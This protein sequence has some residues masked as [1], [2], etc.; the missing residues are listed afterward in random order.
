[1][2]SCA[3]AGSQ[4]YLCRR[5]NLFTG[6]PWHF[7]FSKWADLITLIALLSNLYGGEFLSPIFFSF[8]KKKGAESCCNWLMCGMSGAPIRFCGASSFRTPCYCDFN[9]C[10]I[11]LRTMYIFIVLSFF[12]VHIC[13]IHIHVGIFIVLS[14][15]IACR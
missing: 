15:F 1:M 2:T 6:R 11:S 3:A 5:A 13:K 4:C 14:L 8:F 7:D 9:I 12:I 10:Q